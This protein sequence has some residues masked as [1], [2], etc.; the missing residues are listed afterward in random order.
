MS[1]QYSIEDVQKHNTP[2]DAWVV[3]ENKV[4]T[5]IF[6]QKFILLL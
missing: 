5:N 6:K 2:E 4:K 1:K 3:I